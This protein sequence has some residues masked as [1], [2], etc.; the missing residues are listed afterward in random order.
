MEDF[1]SETDSDYTSYWRDWVGCAFHFCRRGDSFVSVFVAWVRLVS[2]LHFRN[3]IYCTHCFHTFVIP[4][5]G[6]LRSAL[7]PELYFRINICDLAKRH[8]E[9]K[10]ISC[11]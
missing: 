11:S 3:S 5:Q 1:N 2:L 4:H 10:E 9:Q 8:A 6:H 7:W